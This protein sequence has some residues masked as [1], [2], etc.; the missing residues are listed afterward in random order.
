MEGTD[1]IAF[2]QRQISELTMTVDLLKGQL[3]QNSSVIRS[4]NDLLA[5]REETIDRL[6]ESVNRLTEALE[7]SQVDLTKQKN[8]NRGLGKL[9]S[10]KSEKVDSSEDGTFSS[11]SPRPM[12][13]EELDARD[14]RR[15]RERKTRGNNGARH[16]DYGEIEM[17]EVI[18][19]VYPDSP[20]F[21]EQIARLINIYETY[22]FEYVP[23]KFIKH[24][25]RL[26]KYSQNGEMMVGKLPQAPLV[27]S[28]FD[29][30]FIAGVLELRYLYN[31]PE[32]RIVNFFNDHGFP[33]SRKTVNGLLRKSASLL[34]GLY[35]AMGKAVLE[36]KYVSV[37]ETYVKMMLNR[38]AA[39]GKHIKKGY[40]WDIIAHNLGL[41]Y[42]F[43][44]NGSRKAEVIYDKMV[45]YRGTIQSDGFSPYRTLGSDKYPDIMRLPCLQH[46]KR[47]F[48]DMR[49]NPDAR[50]LFDLLN[51]L[52]HNEHLPKK[53][54]W[55]N[56]TQA[57]HARW[58]KRYSPPIIKKLEREIGRI[59]ASPT[60]P[61]D[62]RLKD[63]VT[64]LDNEMAYIPNIFTDASYHL[65]N[66]II[67]RNNR[68]VSLSRHNS[69]FF[70][71]HDGAKRGALF[72]S[73]A[74]SCRMNNLDFFTYIC[75][76]LNLLPHVNPNSP[77][78][79]YR[80][81]LPDKWSKSH[82]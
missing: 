13:E 19:E 41:V 7:K 68:A 42:F 10:N 51:E 17:E 53:K 12:T 16:F 30:S 54:G 65:D 71:S 37:D 35:D 80:E 62:Q 36:D 58:R 64:Y 1:L 32:N 25:W 46:I 39:S 61:V 14:E 76:V 75:E 52:Y 20:L 34:E 67:E 22:R 74:A 4:L 26:R 29:G 21:N 56:W 23:A 82:R 49:D 8:I 24:L 66:N 57:K 48:H 73:L 9:I 79:V 63:A 44:E 33:I 45:D 28:K 5:K 70:G 60:F 6:T 2:Y 47:E 81:L 72:H 3:E 55:K 11:E 43:Y 31:M 69:L 59:K 38:P 27:N 15:R 40:L 78:E 77:Y 50:I 18:H